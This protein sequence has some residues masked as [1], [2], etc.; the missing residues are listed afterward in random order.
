MSMSQPPPP[1]ADYLDDG[2]EL[3][4]L[5]RT[6]AL[7]API[8]RAQSLCGEISRIVL[9]DRVSYLTTHDSSSQ[10]IATSTTATI[11]ARSS[12][13][14][15]LKQLADEVCRIGTDLPIDRQPAN[16]HSGMFGAVETLAIP[17]MTGASIDNVEAVIVLQRYALQPL[18]LAASLVKIRPE[19]DAA[20]A[21]VATAVRSCAAKSERRGARWWRRAPNWQRLAVIATACIGTIGLLYFP[22][23]FRLPVEGRLEPANS[24]GVFAPASGTLTKLH[25]VDGESVVKGT[26][27]AELRNVDIDLQQERLAGEL[28]AAETELTTLRLRQS[29]SAASDSVNPS[30]TGYSRDAG[31]A[32]SRQMVLRSRVQS[33]QE[34][35][36]LMSEVRGSLTIRAPIDGRAILRD[37]Q[38][39]LVGQSISQSQWLMQIVDPADGYEAIIDLPEKDDVYLR[40]SLNTD[41]AVVI[42]DLRLLA[43]P[44]V[45]FSGRVT[46]VADTVL[47]NERGKASIEVTVPIDTL[48]PDDVHVGAS[49]V[50]TIHVGHRSLGFVWFRPIIEFLRS[51]GW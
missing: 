9:A 17:V 38:S 37:E 21:E 31:N 48:L 41:D 12:D 4:W 32:R 11:D 35:T 13:A 40:R 18:S 28:A 47:L 23:A 50:G 15:W 43:S 8:I 46:Q 10:L 45:H 2:F 30:P 22:V 1:N 5:R 33:L 24:F 44:N 29:D 6:D 14:A 49:V 20:A 7:A 3:A 36:S 51:Y 19:I 25:I 16:T 39:D 34:Q 27:L 26:V 42:A